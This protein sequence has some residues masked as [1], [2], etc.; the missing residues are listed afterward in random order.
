MA[1]AVWEWASIGLAT[2]TVFRKRLLLPCDRHAGK[3]CLENE[4]VHA[5]ARKQAGH[6]T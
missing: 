2:W 1:Y 3:Q 4:Q 5:R 6:S